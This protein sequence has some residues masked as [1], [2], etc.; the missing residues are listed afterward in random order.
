MLDSRHLTAGPCAV[1][2]SGSAGL[3]RQPENDDK[4]SCPAFVKTVKTALIKAMTI[5]SR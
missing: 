1:S 5:F 2:T 4:K 3:N